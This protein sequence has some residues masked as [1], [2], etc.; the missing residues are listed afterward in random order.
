MK[1]ILIVGKGGREHALAWKAASSKA[2]GKV[3]VLPGN[4]GTRLEPGVENCDLDELDIAAIISFAKQENID[5]TIIGPEAPLAKGIVDAFQ[6]N[7]LPCFGPTRSAAQLETS[8][9]F[10]KQ[11]MKEEK[12]PTASF[13]VFRQKQAAFDYLDRQKL[14]IVIK[15][16]GLAAGKGVIIAETKKAAKKAITDML[17]KNCFGDAGNEIIIEEYLQGKE[18]S[19]I[20]MVDGKH[21]LPLASSQDHKRREEGDRGPNT[22]GMGAFSPSLLLD[23]SLEERILTT[24]IDPTIKALARRGTPY[25]GFLYAG[26]M[27]TP[28]G[29]PMVLEYN[30]RL[31]DPETQPILL[32]L[33]SDLIELCEAALRQ[34]LHQAHVTW[35]PRPAVCVVLTTAGYPKHS[36]LGDVIDGLPTDKS[37]TS[38]KVF[39]AGTKTAADGSILTQGGRVLGVTALGTDLQEA[40]NTAYAIAE[41]INW[42]GCYYRRDI[43]KNC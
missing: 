20:V 13:A 3:F 25:C 38:C 30:C 4:A 33:K 16:S 7:H 2:V 12:I 43:A 5:L 14:P 36:R 37:E 32:R 21:R 23:S 8:K 39:H 35:D 1:K 40:R 22:G 15:A 6:E 29:E 11:F 31:G 26:L 41:K 9:A 27:I 24:I 19:F 10:C 42:P 34:Q 28:S 18:L 17:E